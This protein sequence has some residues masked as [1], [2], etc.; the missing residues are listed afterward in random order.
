MD[1]KIPA[2][3]VRKT[4]FTLIELLVTIAILS[5]IFVVCF[6]TING[7]FGNS[8]DKVNKITKKMIINAA[9]QYAIEFKDSVDWEEEKESG[10]VTFCVSLDSLINYGYFKQ[11]D[12]KVKKYRN[13][14]IVKMNVVNGVIDYKLVEKTSP[15]ASSC[16]YYEYD[17]SIV[18]NDEEIKIIEN[19]KEIGSFDY[20]INKLSNDKYTTNIYLN[21]DF[22]LIESESGKPLYITILVDNSDSMNSY[23]KFSAAQAAAIDFSKIIPDDAQISLVLY[24]DGP[25]LKRTFSNSELTTSD[26]STSTGYTNISGALDFASSL[27]YN[28]NISPENANFYTILLFDGDSSYYSQIK[29]NYNSLDST[30]LDNDDKLEYY[31]QNFQNFIENKECPVEC[32]SYGY[33]DGYGYQCT[34]AFYDCFPYIEKSSYYLKNRFNSRLISVGYH[35]SDVKVN[36]KKIATKD[37][38]FCLNSD[39]EDYCYYESDSSEVLNLFKNIA[40]QIINIEKLIEAEKVIFR[41]IPAELDG[42]KIFE[43]LEK[44]GTKV[45]GNKI[46]METEDLSSL[47]ASELISINNSYD[48]VFNNNV[49]SKCNENECSNIPLFQTIEIELKYDNGES[50]FIYVDIPTITITSELVKVTN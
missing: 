45:E 9:E 16:V 15:E 4:G 34:N 38:E 21:L 6:L 37:S 44:D 17:T 10:E 1:N 26:F 27:I 14:Y 50:K 19:E 40:D 5:I 36:I 35:L 13:D 49:L 2:K 48:F 46:E 43:I 7:L 24:N 39:Y 29:Y 32:L 3:R 12:E 28:L 33:F 18:K 11:N 47:E 25:V 22:Q 23:S 30:T 41:L 42:D 20:D 31:F 8:E